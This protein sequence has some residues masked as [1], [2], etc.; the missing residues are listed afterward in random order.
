MNLGNLVLII[1]SRTKWLCGF[2]NTV[3]L[4]LKEISKTIKP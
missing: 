1:V 3:Y 2:V 4:R